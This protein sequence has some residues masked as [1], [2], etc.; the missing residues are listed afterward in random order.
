VT[1]AVTF[2]SATNTLT[3]TPVS[4][5]AANTTYT[6]RIRSGVGGVEDLAGNALAAT[7]VWTFTTGAAIDATPP[8]VLSTDPIS[9]ATGVALN[10][11][12]AVNFSEPMNQSR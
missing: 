12:I 10:K 2:V 1:G 8:T 11:K 6:G 5:L 4:G 3:F 7:Y 9:T